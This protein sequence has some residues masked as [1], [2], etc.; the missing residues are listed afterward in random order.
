MHEKILKT[1]DKLAKE[2]NVSKEIF[3][4]RPLFSWF[5]WIEYSYIWKKCN[6]SGDGWKLVRIYRFRRKQ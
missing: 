5:K 1:L 6:S 2:Q 3:Q 4:W